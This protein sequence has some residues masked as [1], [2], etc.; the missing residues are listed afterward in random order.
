MY[1]SEKT[2][3]PVLKTF[4]ANQQTKGVNKRS[5]TGHHT[6]NRHIT[7]QQRPVLYRVHKLHQG[8]IVN[9]TINRHFLIRGQIR[10]F[11]SEGAFSIDTGKGYIH[12]E[13]HLKQQHD[14]F[15]NYSTGF[16]HVTSSDE[17]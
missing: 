9:A 8:D 1:A 2:S 15:Y 3:A 12:K 7:K 5:N 17:R 16:T 4:Q 6:Y 14:L 13:R 11:L 10:L